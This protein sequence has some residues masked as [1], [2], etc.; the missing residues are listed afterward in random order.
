MSFA[1]SIRQEDLTVESASVAND[2][3]RASFAVDV[4][5]EQRNA[6][7][8][9]GRT[10]SRLNNMACRIHWRTGV[11]WDCELLPRFR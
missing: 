1:L 2:V 10:D 7:P 9:A 4:V 5:A 6:Q 11:D 3:R 8:Q